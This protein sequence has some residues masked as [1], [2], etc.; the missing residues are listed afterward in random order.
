M[1]DPVNTNNWS[2]D[3]KERHYYEDLYVNERTILEWV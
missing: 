2:E 3:L 1:R